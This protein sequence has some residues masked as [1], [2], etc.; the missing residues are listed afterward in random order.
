MVD[1][2]VGI[3]EQDV[4]ICGYIHEQRKPSVIAMNKWDIIEKDSFTVNKFND[5]LKEALKFM[6]YFVPVYISAKTGLRT[7]KIINLCDKVLENGRKRIPTGLLNDIIFDCVRA[8][9]PPSFNGKRLKINYVTQVGE[10]P[11]SF[12]FF[13]NDEK[14][15]HFSY[16]R[17]LENCIR[18]AYDFSGTPINISIREKEDYE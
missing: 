12:A 11:P 6:D 1:S 5:D 17:Y 14:L 8:N 10:L 13:V 4:R 2:A 7:E 9:E 18:K 3:T 16:R 15:M